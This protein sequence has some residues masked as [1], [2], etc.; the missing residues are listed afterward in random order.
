[1]AT[2]LDKSKGRLAGL[3]VYSKT[4][5]Q[6]LDRYVSSEDC[7]QAKLL[8]LRNTVSSILEQ[9]AVVH[10]EIINMLEPKDIEAAVVEHM[11]ALQPSYH[12]L[13]KVDLKLAAF[14]SLTPVNTLGA[15]SGNNIQAQSTAVQCRLPK[16]QLSEFSGDPLAWQGFWDQFQVAIHNN[17]RISDIDKFNYLKGCLKG[18]SLSVVSGLSLSSD[19][20][21]EAVGILKDR[22]GNEQI[23][24]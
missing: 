2:A 17:T 14:N 1:M 16:M 4:L 7:E 18:E 13:A 24:T 3:T 12:V 6:E 23:L 11:T 21:Q 10:N 15:S 22:F 19:N 9:L 8:G 20:Y 5:L